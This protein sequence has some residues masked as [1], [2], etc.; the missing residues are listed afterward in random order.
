MTEK[1][2]EYTYDEIEIGLSK[3]FEVLISESMVKNFANISMFKK[4]D[5]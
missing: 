3:Q 1:P 5:F 4:L 2:F